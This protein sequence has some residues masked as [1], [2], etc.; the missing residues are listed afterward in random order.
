MTSRFDTTIYANLADAWGDA[1]LSDPTL[2]LDSTL[3]FTCDPD[4]FTRLTGGWWYFET[5]QYYNVPGAVDDEDICGPGI[6]TRLAEYRGDPWH[7]IMIICPAVLEQTDGQPK[8]FADLEGT[9][10]SH[11]T[12]PT[13]IHDPPLT[14]EMTL[15]MFG[16]EGMTIDQLRAKIL[17]VYIG[18]T[19]LIVTNAMYAD[20]SYI[21]GMTESFLTYQGDW[22]THLHNSQVITL[23]PGF[24]QL[25]NTTSGQSDSKRGLALHVYDR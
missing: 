15:N 24:L 16:W 5:V 19:I 12:R 10:L 22:R 2:P 6:K 23:L 4:S 17:S 14:E 11:N 13:E 18:R 7:F 3:C 9:D 8:M 20:H 21:S 25:Q 1:E